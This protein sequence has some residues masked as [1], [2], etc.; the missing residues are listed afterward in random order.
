MIYIAKE[1]IY[2]GQHV[3]IEG[4]SIR[5]CPHG[6]QADALAMDDVPEGA[7]ARKSDGL[8]RRYRPITILGR[9]NDGEREG[10]SVEF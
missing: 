1:H 3:V 8:I 7:F 2:I 9:L 10:N 5:R 4:S 6:R